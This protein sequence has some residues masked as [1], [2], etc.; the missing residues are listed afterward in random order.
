M[1]IGFGPSVNMVGSDF[2]GRF[3]TRPAKSSNAALCG[4]C[5]GHDGDSEVIFLT[6]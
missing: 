1:V 2:I 3:V 6:R 4:P 5:H